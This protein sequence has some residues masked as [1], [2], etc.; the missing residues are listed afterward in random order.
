MVLD[1]MFGRIAPGMCRL[2][3]NGEIA[4]KTSSGYKTYQMNTGKLTNCDHF[5]LDI[6]EEFFFLLPTNKVKAGDILLAGGKPKCVIRAEKECF[7]VINY[8]NALVESLLPE[9][10]VFMGDTY[11][12]GKIVSLFGHGNGKKKTGG[13]RILHYMMLSEMLKGNKT[14]LPFLLMS[15]GKNGLFDSMFDD[16]EEPDKETV[17][18]MMDKTTDHH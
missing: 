18:E 16:E 5:I 14:A 1:G 12:F 11:F 2:S 3:I 6:G 4:V 17:D 15:Q 8:E 10:H 9:Y 13:R 7:T